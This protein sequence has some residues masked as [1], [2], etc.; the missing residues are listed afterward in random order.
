MFEQRETNPVSAFGRLRPCTQASVLSASSISYSRQKQTPPLR[1]FAPHFL[2][3]L[4]HSRSGRLRA[5]EEVSSSLPPLH[6]Y[7]VQPTQ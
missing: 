2:T 5:E 4:A 1:V 3:T 6:S 7:R